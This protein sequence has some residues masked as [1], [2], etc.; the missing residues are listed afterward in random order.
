MENKEIFFYQGEN[1]P[2]NNTMEARIKPTPREQDE[3]ETSVL[4]SYFDV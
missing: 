1:I 4:L 2:I 3:E